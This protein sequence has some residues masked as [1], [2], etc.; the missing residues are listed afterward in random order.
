MELLTLGLFAAALLGCIVAG[1]PTV[2]AVVIGLVL[3]CAYAWRS[4]HSPKG[5]LIMCWHGIKPI[6]RIL[7]MLLLVGMLAVIAAGILSSVPLCAALQGMGAGEVIQTALFGYVAHNPAVSALEGGGVTSMVSA[8]GIVFITSAYAG[9]FEETDLLSGVEHLVSAF[10]Q[11]VTPFA[12]TLGISALTA[13]VS[14]NQTLAIML[15][16]QLSDGLVDDAREH[17]VDLE[18]SVVLVAGLV[19]WSIAGGVP[20]ASMGAPIE[21]MALA[22]FLYAV[23][24]WRLACSYRRPRSRLAEAPV[25]R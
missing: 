11:R 23:P 1:A 4:G 24:L 9:I 21:S 5:V 22:V 3:F 25:G 14:C 7:C 19:P 12:A 16:N 13:M 20:L 15:A 10:A 18:D 17:A 8:A 2:L 6:R